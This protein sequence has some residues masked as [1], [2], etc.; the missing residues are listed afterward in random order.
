M[1]ATITFQ[2]LHEFIGDSYLNN[3]RHNV[4]YRVEKLI[5]WIPPINGILKLN[6]NG[7]RINN[8]STLRWVIKDSNESI[9][10]TG[11]RHLGINASIINT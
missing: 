2:N 1:K 7:S 11:N 5:R 8:I 10:M 9:K 6:F 3:E 4:P